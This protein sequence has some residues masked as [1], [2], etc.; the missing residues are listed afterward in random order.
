MLFPVFLTL[1]LLNKNSCGIITPIERVR[2]Q[3]NRKY[4]MKSVFHRIHKS[5]DTGK[6]TAIFLI[7]VVILFLLVST[8][9]IAHEADHECTGEDCPVCALI[10]MSEN[11]LRQLGSGTPAAAVA[12]SLCVLLLVMQFCTGDSITFPTPV[13][14]KTRLNN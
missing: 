3:E 1:L 7:L 10:Q 8:Y 11:S 2:S 6:I 12:S 5:A 9:F 4:Q 14:R 13:S